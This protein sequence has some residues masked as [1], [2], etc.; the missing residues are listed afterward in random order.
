LD[1]FEDNSI[2]F[3]KSF[4]KTLLLVTYLLGLLEQVETES[5]QSCFIVQIKHQSIA[6]GNQDYIADHE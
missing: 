5:K 3:N 2:D 4:F 1:S 6:N